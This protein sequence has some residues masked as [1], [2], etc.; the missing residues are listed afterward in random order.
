MPRSRPE[1]LS[2]RTNR[3]KT[4]PRYNETGERRVAGGQS[5]HV[6]AVM[7]AAIAGLPSVR[8]HLAPGGQT[9]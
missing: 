4:S 3:V 5:A 2:R 6:A 7:A 8:L 9:A 1:N